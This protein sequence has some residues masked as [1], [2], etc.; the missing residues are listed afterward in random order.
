MQ[1]YNFKARLV[2]E[3]FKQKESVEL[4]IPVLVLLECHPLVLIAIASIHQLLVNQVDEN[5]F[6]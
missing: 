5:S 4:F 1:R 2:G 6:S 3:G